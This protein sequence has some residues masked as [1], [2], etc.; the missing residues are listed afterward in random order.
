M[1]LSIIAEA[2]ARVEHKLDALLRHHNVPV[3]PMHFTGNLCAG[4][5][6]VVDYQI[7]IE[8]QVVVRKCQCKTGKIPSPIP[9][10]PVVPT[11]GASPH[12]NPPPDEQQLPDRA[13]KGPRG[14]AR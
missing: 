2:L 11:P 12:G 6:T 10:L 8:H 4:C 5:G 9:L 14:K 1:G 7:D 3:F 13:P